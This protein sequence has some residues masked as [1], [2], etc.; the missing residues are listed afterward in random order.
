MDLDVYNIQNNI[1]IGDTSAK[2]QLTSGQDFV[3]INSIVTKLNSQLPDATIALILDRA[4]D[5]RKLMSI[6]P[7][8]VIVPTAL[9]RV[10]LCC[11]R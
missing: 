1:K 11:V 8:I 6:I 4:C 7:L 2:I 10:C 9:L 3:M 5:S